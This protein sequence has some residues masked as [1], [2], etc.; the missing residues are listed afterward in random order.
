MNQPTLTNERFIENPFATEEDKR[1]G[2]T[3]LYKTGD[4]VRWLEDGNIEYSGRNDFQVKIRGFRIELNEI[5]QT[6]LRFKGIQQSAVLAQTKETASG[7]TTYLVAYYVSSE[8]I[9]DE[10]LRAHFALSLPEYMI[11]SAFVSLPEFPLTVNGKLD[12]KALPLP[13]FK[14]NEARYVAPRDELEVRICDVWQLSLGLERVGILDDFF[15]L[16][17]HSILAIQ[18]A[19][20]MSQVMNCM[21]RVADIFKYRTISQLSTTLRAGEALTAIPSQGTQ[22][23]VLSYAQ[24]R[25]WFIEQ[26]EGG[27]D[28]YHV[29]MSFELVGIDKDALKQALQAIV[30]RHA[31]LRTVFKQVESGNYLQC[32]QEEALQIA[33]VTADTAT[34][35]EIVSEFS[36]RVFDLKKDYP[37]RACICHL[38][39]SNQDYLLMTIHHIAF[40]E[41]SDSVFRRELEL[42]YEAFRLNQPMP[43]S[44]LAIQYKD[45]A[46]WQRENLSA[47]MES[48]V[49]Y[50]QT[51]LANH[52]SLMMPLDYPRPPQMDYRGDSVGF[53]LSEEVSRSLH[54]LADSQGLTVYTVLLSGFALLLSRYTGQQDL[55]I[56]TPIA[57]RQH[58]QLAD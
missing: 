50:W 28:A 39:D 41:W 29:P 56:G 42:C 9:D 48:L 36:H 4:L 32:I 46:V 44:A 47:R 16:G 14:G 15:R 54:D 43:L 53:E 55:L 22:E 24:E 19:H 57:N 20:R 8:A 58:P 18:V 37:I 35:D 13:D 6:L 26:Y 51:K 27:T 45:F 1:Q 25:L 40:D 49:G 11:P 38:E 31:V 17:G 5:E 30:I 10:A 33:E 21:I 3:R 23:G 2:Y 52:E 12:R 34:F 7:K